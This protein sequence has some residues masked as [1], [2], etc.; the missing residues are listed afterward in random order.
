MMANSRH[1]PW[2]QHHDSELPAMDL[3]DILQLSRGWL[4]N[5]VG[6]YPPK[7][8]RSHQRQV[9]YAN[10]LTAKLASRDSHLMCRSVFALK[11]P[12]QS[13]KSQPRRKQYLR[14]CPRPQ[15]LLQALLRTPLLKSVSLGAQ[16][17]RHTTS[18]HEQLLLLL[19]STH[20]FRAN[21]DVQQRCKD[22]PLSLLHKQRRPL[23]MSR[24]RRR[25]VDR[26]RKQSLPR[27]HH[28]HISLACLPRKTMKCLLMLSQ[29]NNQALRKSA[30]LVC[31]QNRPMMN[32]Q[33]QSLLPQGSARLL[34]PVRD[35]RLHHRNP[36]ISGRSH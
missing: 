19:A 11:L 35:A 16:R 36:S 18:K 13:S 24:P 23:A 3:P 25:L 17:G 10:C 9:L 27:S 15:P 34:T 5:K 20:Q 8:N 2:Q 1:R 14:S 4:L 7:A 26:N 30:S 12:L 22:L 33:T 6:K 21:R 32:A 29:N 28:K 31:L